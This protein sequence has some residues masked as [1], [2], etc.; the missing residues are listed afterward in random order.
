MLVKDTLKA[1][2]YFKKKQKSVRSNAFLIHKGMHNLKEVY[3]IHY[4]LR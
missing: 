1:F 4:T 3:L 2:N